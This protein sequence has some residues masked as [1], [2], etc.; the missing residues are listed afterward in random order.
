MTPQ[1][2]EA[3]IRRLPLYYRLL[4]A[5]QARRTLAVSS[6]ELGASLGVSAAQVRRDLTYFGRFGTKRQGYSVDRL[7]AE[8]RLLL[9]LE[10]RWRMVLVG[11]GH[12]GQAIAA[13]PGFAPE[14]FDLEA[15]YEAASEK[16]GIKVGEFVVRDVRMLPK[17]LRLHPADIAIV[18]VPGTEAQPVVDELVRAG[19][20]AILS[21]AP[22]SLKVPAGV[23]LRQVDPVAQ[24]QG[25]TYYLSRPRIRDMR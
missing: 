22:A 17:D 15:V 11:A 20:C 12:L 8:L 6:E 10:R 5:L 14:G 1:I 16:I 21:Y 13:Y 9:G 3:V 23:E 24:L 4:R 7:R 18:T 25:M 2:P 19:V